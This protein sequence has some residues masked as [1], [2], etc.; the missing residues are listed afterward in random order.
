MD[1]AAGFFANVFGGERFEDYVRYLMNYPTTSTDFQHLLDRRNL[2]NEGDD[3]R[4]LGRHDRRRE[5]RNGT[6]SEKPGRRDAVE[7]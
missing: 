3:Q 2:S 1:D 4:C 5:G 7:H 6:E